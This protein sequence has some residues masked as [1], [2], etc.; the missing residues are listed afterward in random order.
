[1]GPQQLLRTHC[2]IRYFK[3]LYYSFTND[4]LDN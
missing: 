4:D 2:F 1:M 3:R